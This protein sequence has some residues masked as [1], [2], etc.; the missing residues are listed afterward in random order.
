[1]PRYERGDWLKKPEAPG[2]VLQMTSGERRAFIEG[3]L[4]GEGGIFNSNGART[5]AFHQNPGPVLEAFRLACFLEG[6]AT[7]ERRGSDKF[8]C[9]R[10]V[11]LAKRMRICDKLK[12]RELGEDEVWCPSTGLGTWVMRQGSLITIT[13]N[14]LEGGEKPAVA[15][16]GHYH[17]QM[18]MMWRNVWCIQP[19][20][21]QDQTPFM[22]KKKIQAHVGGALVK[23][24]QDPE[25]GAI[26]GCSP[27]MWQ[28]FNTGYYQHRW[29]MSGR[30]QMAERT[31]GGWRVKPK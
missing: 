14:S 12:R 19:G 20:C 11:L 31:I 24:E 1:L 3:M 5:V 8:E 7:T 21:V 29:S 10:A 17:K 18:A 16:Y 13:G 28:Y 15:I 2:R 26:I 25:T 23:L 6:I 27:S 4:L 9:R 22:R 30:P